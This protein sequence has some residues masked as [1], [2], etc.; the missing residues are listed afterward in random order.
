MIKELLYPPGN[1]KRYSFKGSW[2]GWGNPRPFRWDMWLFP[3]GWFLNWFECFGYP[4]LIQD[5][6][7]VHREYDRVFFMVSLVACRKL[8]DCAQLADMDLECLLGTWRRWPILFSTRDTLCNIYLHTILYKFLFWTLHQ[9]SEMED[10]WW[11][12]LWIFQMTK[13][14]GICVILS[15]VIWDQRLSHWSNAWKD[16]ERCRFWLLNFQSTTEADRPLQKNSC[17]FPME[18]LSKGLACWSWM[19]V[20]QFYHKTHFVV[21]IQMNF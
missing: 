10:R 2:K 1:D 18:L 8:P 7:G 9:C 21:R 6:S 14:D 4:K 12:C 5:M 15:E 19:K 11:Q 13:S 3:E 17:L 20:E 16:D